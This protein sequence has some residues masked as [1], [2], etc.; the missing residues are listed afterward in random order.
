MGMEL[1]ISGVHIIPMGMANAYLIEGDD[2]LTLIDAGFPNKQVAVF[3]SIRGLGRSPDQL[4][5]LIFTHG[6][7]DHIGSAAAI[8][9]GTGAR[10]YMHPLDI[11]IA[12]SGGPFRPMTPAPGLLRQVMCRLFFHPDER[13]EPVAIDQPLIDGEIL[14]IAGGIEVIHVPGHCAGQVALL[15]HPGRM[16]FAADVC[17]NLMGLADPVGFENLEEGRASQRKLASLSFDAAGFGHGKPIARD[18]SAQ[19]RNKWG[20]KSSGSPT[21]TLRPA[22]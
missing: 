16:L 19:F 6:H 10:T 8:V 5:D 7:P 12:E 22:A 3:E 4:K 17:M 11:P 14:P 21:T 2:R 15:W 20:K 1:V 9:R 13:L 18:A